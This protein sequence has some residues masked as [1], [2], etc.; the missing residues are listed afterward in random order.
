MS[1]NAHAVL[2]ASSSK[3]WLTCTPSARLEQTLPEPKRHPN[4]FDF[5]AEGT[6]AHTLSELKLKLIYGQIT[7][8]EYDEEYTK[9]KQSVYYTEDFEHYIDVYVLYVRSQ[10]GENDKAL[11]EQ[12]VDF[13]DWVPDGFGT[14]DVVILSKNTIH[15][16]DLKFGKGIPVDAKDNSQLRLY[17]LGA[18]SKFSEE[19]PDIKK[20][21][22]TIHQPRLDSISSD[23]TTVDKLLD[24]SNY[25]VKQK[26]KRAWAGTG[27][28]IPGDH[29]QFC[30]AKAQC[31][32]RAD[33]SNEVATLDFRTPAL[34]SEEEMELVLSRAGDV[35]SWITDVEAFFTNRAITENIIPKGYKLVTGKGNRKISDPDLAVVVLKEHGF[36]EEDL[37]APKTLKSIV[38]LEK[39]GNKGQVASTLGGLIL[40]PET[41]PKLVKDTTVLE[42]FA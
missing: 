30:R 34:I 16:I 35:K 26:A 28:F 31:R 3:R 5:S 33:F 17:G 15:V 12:R 1:A 27:D 10:I 23:E 38:Q 18:W 29:C 20:V 37:Y 2:S 40:R 11:F 6:A 8:E 39:L 4:A 24:W 22:Y 42:D 9:I 32:A 36:K 41:A 13:S 14:A 7:K 25:F 21:R 19:Y